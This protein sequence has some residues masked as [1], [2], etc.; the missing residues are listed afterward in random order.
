MLIKAKQNTTKTQ[1][2]RINGS[3]I[4]ATIQHIGINSSV[5]VNGISP[6]QIHGQWLNPESSEVEIFKSEDLW[7]DP[8]PYIKDEK[9]TVLIDRKNPK[10]YH[11]DL[12]FLPK[13]SD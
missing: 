11:V 4:T 2:L 3:K 13:I 8:T 7:Y 6:Y 9:V 12:S 1:D 5:S 10:R